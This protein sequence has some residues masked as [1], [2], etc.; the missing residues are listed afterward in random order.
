MAKLSDDEIRDGLVGL[1]DWS[2]EGDEIVRNYE[3]DSFPAVIAFVGRIADL[4]EAADHHPDL[5]IRYNRLRVALTSHD[6]GG[7][8]KRDF[9]LATSIEAALDGT[10]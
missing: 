2:R 8:T 10:S 5:D 9:K 1:P 4:A 6:S 3:L 7:L